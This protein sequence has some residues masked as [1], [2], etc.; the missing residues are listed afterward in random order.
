MDWQDILMSLVFPLPMWVQPTALRSELSSPQLHLRQERSFDWQK[1][2]GKQHPG[3]WKNLSF[4][5]LIFGHWKLLLY[6]DANL[7][8]KN[9][10]PPWDENLLRG[11]WPFVSNSLGL[12]MWLPLNTFH[13]PCIRVS[14]PVPCRAGSPSWPWASMTTASR[15]INM[16]E[17][18][19]APISSTSRKHYPACLFLLFFFL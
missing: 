16:M 9:E 6:G 10:T 4:S 14:N 13:F 11:L 1:K 7:F 15:E 3:E 19:R 5:I 12:K 18:H 17:T 8:F 2:D